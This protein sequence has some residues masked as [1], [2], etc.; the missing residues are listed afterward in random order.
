M[1]HSKRLMSLLLTGAMLLGLVPAF[2]TPARAATGEYI[3]VWCGAGKIGN[4]D[5]TVTKD[6]GFIL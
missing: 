6:F 3:E 2:S 5:M 4:G 1:K